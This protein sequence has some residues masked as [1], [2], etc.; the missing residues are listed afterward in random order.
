M[1]ALHKGHISLIKRARK[2]AGR[3][4]TVAVSIFVNPTQFGPKEDLSKYPR[5]VSEDNA[6]CRDSDVD[7]L[8]RPTPEDMY[9]EDRSIWV[10][11][12]VLS[13]TLCGASRP[14]HFRGVCS[15]VAKFFNILQPDIAIFGEK[16]WQQLA[17]IRRM[18]RDLNFPVEI[19]GAPI[20]REKDGLAMSSRNRYLTP[21][22]RQAAPALYQ[23]LLEALS[24]Y[25]SGE[26]KT[27]RL[28][29][30]IKKI[31]GGIPGARVDYIQ[32]VESESLK[33]VSIIQKPATIALAVFFGKARLIDN[34]QLSAK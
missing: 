34:I 2:I 17:I 30:R 29:S 5:P 23:A 25:R 18:V 28:T 22:E 13:K 12:E 32:V 6:I 31:I 11:E 26:V 20:V 9:F 7:L 3:Q 14:G 24:L 1:G 27:S 19:C 15:V 4:G 21:T 33:S 8:F 16:D 10:N